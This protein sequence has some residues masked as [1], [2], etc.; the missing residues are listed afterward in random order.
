MEDLRESV[1]AL[2]DMVE[3]LMQRRS[4]RGRWAA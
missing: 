3:L 2:R 1:R 4:E